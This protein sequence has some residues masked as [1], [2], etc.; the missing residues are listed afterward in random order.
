MSKTQVF[1]SQITGSLSSEINDGVSLATPST[2]IY[3]D[4]NKIRTQLKKVLNVDGTWQDAPSLTLYKI[5]SMFTGTLDLNNLKVFGNA[6]ID[7]DLTV[8][9]SVSSLSATNTEIKDAIIGLGFSSGSSETVAGDRGWI[10]GLGEAGRVAMIWDNSESEFAFGRTSSNIT[11][12]N[13]N[14]SE[15][16]NLHAAKIQGSIITASLGFSGS[17]TKLSDGT[18]YLIAGSNITLSTGSNGS[19]TI[20]SAGGS[21][22]GGQTYS[23][24]FF[25]GSSQDGSGNIDVSSIGTLIGGYNDISDIDVFLNGQL[26]IAGS[27]RDY[28]VPTNSSVHFNTSLQ[29]DDVVIVR[30]LTMGSTGVVAEPLTIGAT[31]MAPTKATTKV[32]D[33]IQ[34]TDD[35]SGWCQVEASYFAADTAGAEAGNGTYLFT[36]PGSYQFDTTTHPTNTQSNVL[37]GWE[38]VNKM[39]GAT[40]IVSQDDYSSFNNYVVPYSSTQFRIIAH[41]PTQF[42]YIGNSYYS[43]TVAN[44]QFRLSFRFR[45]A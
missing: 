9:G 36:L 18:S 40:G 5:N 31:I 26:L 1:Q 21:G 43:L 11:S 3:D 27:S 22:S 14:F 29:P 13:I 16:S 24:G 41:S 37:S 44:N 35:G 32:Q 20:N 23:K 25:Y 15:Y 2:T 19:I 10:G 28:T 33:F 38:Q 12:E 17:L 30:L 8:L 39:I 7:G 34:L 4:L 42:T 6:I 45:K